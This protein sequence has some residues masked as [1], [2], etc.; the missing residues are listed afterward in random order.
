MMPSA[1]A[2]GAPPLPPEHPLPR[3]LVEKL[4]KASS[5]EEAERAIKDALEFIIK[6][7]RELDTRTEKELNPPV[8][9]FNPEQATYEE[10]EEK[11]IQSWKDYAIEL[12]VRMEERMNTLPEKDTEHNIVQ[13]GLRL[14][15]IDRYLLAQKYHP[16]V[17]AMLPRALKDAM[18]RYFVWRDSI[19]IDPEIKEK[20]MELEL[21][22][23]KVPPHMNPEKW[24]EKLPRGYLEAL[25]QLLR[26]EK[27]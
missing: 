22:I 1:P 13:R 5:V 19:Y 15:P 20:L 14:H 9:V 4:T 16:F 25:A 23:A 26:K 6:N 27:V 17:V 21:E 11:L 7:K 10:V 3:G 2:G 24:I 8:Y 12:R 18:F